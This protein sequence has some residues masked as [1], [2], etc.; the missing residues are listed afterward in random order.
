MSGQPTRAGSRVPLP[1]TWRQW[2]AFVRRPSLPDRA[3]LSIPRGLKAIGPLF[4]LDLLLMA[5]LL[6]AVG[7]AM[8]LGFEMPR[9][10]MNDMKLSAP[11]LAFF[12]IGA[13]IGEEILFRGWLSGRAGHVVGSLLLTAAFGLLMLGA[14]PGEELWSFGALGLL[15][16]AGVFLFLLRGRPAMPWFQRHFAWFYWASVLLF[17]VIHLTNFAA[18]GP[19]MLPLVLPQF[20]LAMILGYLRVRHGLWSSVLLHMLHNSVFMALVLAGSTAA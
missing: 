1:A 6:G 16:A 8:A 13:P 18:A 7:A 9:H 20:A 14:R 5:V 11:L 15:A 19:A 17:A 2:G 12:V 3:D 10:M 4:G